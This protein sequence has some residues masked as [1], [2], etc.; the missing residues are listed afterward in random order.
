MDAL[1]KTMLKSALSP[2]KNFV[3]IIKHFLLLNNRAEAI[4]KYTIK[5]IYYNSNRL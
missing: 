5:Y 2:F 1:V 3:K 4:V